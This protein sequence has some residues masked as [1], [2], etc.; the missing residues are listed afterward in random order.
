MSDLNYKIAA[1][2]KDKRTVPVTFISGEI[3]HK[4]DVN[5]VLTADGSYDKTGTKVRVEE[6]AL[7]VAHKI[8][9]GVITVPV[10]MEMPAP[11]VATE[12]AASATAA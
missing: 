6:V 2:D 10:D 12:A 5:A 7:G 4:R 9:L 1:F 11:A 3:E 8:G